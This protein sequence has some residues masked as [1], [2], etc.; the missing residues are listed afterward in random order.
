MNAT[1][2]MLMAFALEKKVIVVRIASTSFV[3]HGLFLYHI[4]TYVCYIV[5]I[6]IIGV[7]PI[8]PYSL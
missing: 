8:F 5:C 3:W 4:T 2:S 1:S 6:L 7:L